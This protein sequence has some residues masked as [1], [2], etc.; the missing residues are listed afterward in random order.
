MSWK[1]WFAFLMIG[2]LLA[3]CKTI[4]TVKSGLNDLMQEDVAEIEM[5]V[6]ERT[7]VESQK[8]PSHSRFVIAAVVEEMH[9]RG[10]SKIRGSISAGDMDR[11]LAG[12]V[13]FRD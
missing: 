1:C 5:V 8:V 10:Q 2:A 9:D 12:S 7:L 11:T 13:A 6:P 3:G 4:S